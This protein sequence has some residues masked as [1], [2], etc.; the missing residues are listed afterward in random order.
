VWYAAACCHTPHYNITIKVEVR[1][2]Y[3]LTTTEEREKQGKGGGERERE[4]GKGER[5]KVRREKLH[6]GRRIPPCCVIHAFKI[7]N[8]KALELWLL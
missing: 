6:L 5:R 8:N 3:L 7:S 2:G 4:E 1:W